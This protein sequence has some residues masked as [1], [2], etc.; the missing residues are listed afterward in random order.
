[1]GD[2]HEQ[3]SWGKFFKGF[4]DGRNYAKAVVLMVCMAVII[5]ICFSV[6]TV[7]SNKFAKKPVIPTQTIGTNEGTVTTNNTTEEKHGWQL[8]GG[9][10]QVNT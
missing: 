1:M 3:W 2:L 9:L 4:F 6:Y 7:I 8:F 10:I 5:T